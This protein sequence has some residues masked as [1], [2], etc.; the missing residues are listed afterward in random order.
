MD[1]TESYLLV[2]SVKNHSIYRFD[3]EGWHGFPEK[4]YIE[5]DDKWSQG[6]ISGLQSVPVYYRIPSGGNIF[7]RKPFVL[8]SD[9]DTNE[10][11]GTGIIVKSSTSGS[12]KLFNIT[13]D[14]S[15]TISATEV[16]A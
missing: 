9:E 12:S 14:D 1:V 8:Y 7:R 6:Y 16:T 5:T 13:V 3:Y 2:A 10:P 15:G 4:H 11:Y